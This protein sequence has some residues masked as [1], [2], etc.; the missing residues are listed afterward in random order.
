MKLLPASFRRSGVSF[1]MSPPMMKEYVPQV[2]SSVSV[3]DSGSSVQDGVPP[4][5]LMGFKAAMPVVATVEQYLVHVKRHL[6]TKIT[7]SRS[8]SGTPQILDENN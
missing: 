5:K 7:G 3:S 1:G 2:I 8:R 4:G 6:K